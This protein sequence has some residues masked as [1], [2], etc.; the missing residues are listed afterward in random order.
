MATRNIVALSLFVA[1]ISLKLPQAIETRSLETLLPDLPFSELS[2]PEPDAS[3]PSTLANSPD[4]VS[5]QAPQS[6]TQSNL[7]RIHTCNGEV[8]R[9][10]FREF[11]TLNPSAILGEIKWGDSVR[12]KGRVIQAEG[13]MWHEAIAPALASSR[14]PAAQNQLEPGQTGWIAGCFVNNN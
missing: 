5:S 4:P 7:L 8:S 2:E 6:G 12:L 10:N 14:E 3:P 9:A 1:A 13:V 11:P